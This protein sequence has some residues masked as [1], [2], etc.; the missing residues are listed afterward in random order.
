M[1]ENDFKENRR[2]I[3]IKY[4]FDKYNSNLINKIYM[5]LEENAKLERILQKFTYKNQ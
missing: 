4:K 5:N 2:S 1:K 3:I